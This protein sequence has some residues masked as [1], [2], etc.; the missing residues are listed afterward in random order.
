MRETGL[1][2]QRSTPSASLADITKHM[3]LSQREA[4]TGGYLEKPPLLQSSLSDPLAAVSPVCVARQ[5]R[6]CPHTSTVQDD[7]EMGR[8]QRTSPP[9]A[10]PHP[11]R[12]RA[13]PRRVRSRWRHGA[14]A[15]T[16][17]PATPTPTR[18]AATPGRRRSPPPAPRAPPSPVS[19]WALCQ[20]VLAAFPHLHH[21]STCATNDRFTG[22]A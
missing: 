7:V 13:H 17:A 1:L 8:H 11:R 2:L 10:P 16:R 12:L 14:G 18:R 6:V 15:G 9:P 3:P 21:S 22:R 20:P 4:I 5:V 19:R